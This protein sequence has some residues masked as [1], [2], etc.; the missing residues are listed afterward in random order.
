M[1]R[2]IP[3]GREITTIWYKGFPDPIYRATEMRYFSHWH[4]GYTNWKTGQHLSGMIQYK[5]EVEIDHEH[6]KKQFF[7]P[8]WY[9]WRV[10]VYDD[11]DEKFA[12]AEFKLFIIGINK[13]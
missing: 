5:V 13:I 1:P 6:W 2:R 12:C 10:E 11:F 4:H 9:N 3:K 7:S 8:G